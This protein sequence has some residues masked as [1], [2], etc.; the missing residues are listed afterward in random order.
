MLHYRLW[1]SNNVVATWQYNTRLFSP[2]ISVFSSPSSTLKIGWSGLS[3]FRLIMSFKRDCIL[4]S[5]LGTDT[6]YDYL[7]YQLLG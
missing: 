7:D 2:S 6:K 4:Q 1:K 3:R 5:V